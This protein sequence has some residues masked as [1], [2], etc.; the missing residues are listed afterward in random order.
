MARNAATVDIGINVPA[1]EIR[2]AEQQLG[3][4]FNKA[5]AF[6]K[7]PIVSKNY[8]QPLGRITGAANEFN[9]SLAAS[10]ARV[11]AFGASAGAIFA[12]QKAMSELVKTTI[13]VEQ[14][15][16]NI[17]VLLGATD[18]EFRRFSDGLFKTAQA[19][20]KSFA[21]VAASAEEFARQ[22]LNVE[23][24]LK[25]NNA[26]MVLSKLGAMDVKNA[27]ESLTAAINTF[28]KSAGD[29]TTIV[30]KLAQV[31]AKFAVSSGDL[32]EAIKRSGAAAVSANVEFEQFISV[33][34]LAQERTA[35]GGAVIGNSF[36]TI[37]T[38][39][40]RNETLRELE[41]L[42]VATRNFSTG[43]LLPAMTILKNYAK[44]YETLAPTVKASTAQM[45]AGVFQVNVLK[46]VLPELAN[47]YGRYNQALNVANST[48]NEATERMKELTSTTQGMLNKT[49]VNL[50]KFASE[51]GNL[52]IKPALER[53]LKLMNG[54]ADLIGP[55]NFFGLGETIGTAVY[56]GMGKIIE[57]P[58]LLLL[59]VVIAKI[60]GRLGGYVKD[61]AAGFMGI[62]TQSQ[63]LADTQSIIQNLLANRP[64]L[65]NQAMAS[66]EGMVAVVRVLA[67]KLKES[68]MEM[69]RLTAAAQRAA[70][71]VLAM[72]GGAKSAGGKK[73]GAKGFVPGFASG[74][75]PNFNMATQERRMASAGGYQAG[76]I[77]EA[78]LPGVGRVTYNGNEKI[79][80]FPGLEQPGIM[81]PA[82]SPAGK[83]YRDSFRGV[84]G[85]DPY[86]SAGGFVPNFAAKS[87]MIGGKAYTG[88]QVSAMLRPTRTQPRAFTAEEAAAAGYAPSGTSQAQRAAGV[89]RQNYTTGK[90]VTKRD[91]AHTHPFDVMGK[92]GIL[93]FTSEVDRMAQASMFIKNISAMNEVVAMNPALANDKILFNNV[94]VRGVS[95]LSKKARREEKFFSKISDYLAQPLAELTQFFSQSV[96]GN[97][98]KLNTRAI[99]KQLKGRNALLPPGAEGD[100]FEAVVKILTTEPQ[101]LRGAFDAKRNFKAPFDFEEV[102]KATPKFVN[103]FGFADTL[104]R[105]DAKRS[106]TATTV[107]TVVKK[108]IN[109]ALLNPSRSFAKAMQGAPGMSKDSAITPKGAGGKAGYHTA[110]TRTTAAIRVGNLG[111]ALGFVPNFAAAGSRMG[112]KEAMKRSQATVSAIQREHQAGIPKNQIRVGFDKRIAGGVGVF[113]TSETS[114]GN[115]IN[116]HMARGASMRD[117]QTMGA[118]GGFVPNFET[119][120]YLAAN[121]PAHKGGPVNLDDALPKQASG[122]RSVATQAAAQVK[123]A[124]N[125]LTEG[126]M[127]MSMALMMA[128]SQASVFGASL[129]ESQSAVKRAAGEFISL[130][131]TVAMYY[132]VIQMATA[133]MG[134]IS[135]ALALF[136]TKI[137]A[138]G[139]AI[140]TS[141]KSFI[142]NS[143]AVA[144]STVAQGM[145][146]MMFGVGGGM[147]RG[148]GRA[149]AAYKAGSM[150]KI[151]GPTL[152]G[153]PGLGRTKIGGLAGVRG[154]LA[155]VGKRMGGVVGMGAR[156]GA[157]VLGGGA[158]TV[159]AGAAAAYGGYK[160]YQ[161][162]N[163]A[164]F[165]EVS[166]KLSEELNLAKDKTEKFGK[167]L[168]KAGEVLSELDKQQRAG[169][170]TTKTREQLVASLSGSAFRDMIGSQPGGSLSVPGVGDGSLSRAE[171]LKIMGDENTSSQARNDIMTAATKLKDRYARATDQ[172]EG[173]NAVIDTIKD[174]QGFWRSTSM[175]AEDIAK[176]GGNLADV[177]GE[178]SSDTA[179]RLLPEL[180]KVEDA[181]SNLDSETVLSTRELKVA[182][183]KLGDFLKNAPIEAKVRQQLIGKLKELTKTTNLSEDDLHDFYKKVLPY[184]KDELQGLAN[185]GAFVGNN[186][187]QIPIDKLHNAILGIE[188]EFNALGR[189]LTFNKSLQAIFQDETTKMF[190]LASKTL[191][192]ELGKTAS[193]LTKIQITQELARRRVDIS[194]QDKLRKIE[195]D[196]SKQMFDIVKKFVV[197][198][199]S[200]TE[201]Q[202]GV[203]PDFETFDKVVGGSFAK[204]MRSAIADADFASAQQLIQNA[205]NNQK[206]L[207]TAG[208]GLKGGTP[209]RDELLQ[210]ERTLKDLN[211]T[212]QNRI[213]LERQR[214]ASEKRYIDAQ[215]Q[216]AEAQLSFAQRLKFLGGIQGAAGKPQEAR[217]LFLQN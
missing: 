130:A 135:G 180:Q 162:L 18:K 28:G 22:G 95:K 201:A 211:A 6:N 46:S 165:G 153:Q 116:M 80:Q 24:T 100:I 173:I 141:T 196:S 26:A 52:T 132:P 119:I 30:N 38:R 73:I 127:M 23:A 213:E 110:D 102:G 179:K 93:G 124:S 205:L 115:A 9:K 65:I 114:L 75:V 193:E 71:A 174:N 44:V 120:G 16:K 21:D 69:E 15:L 8:T 74:F 215:K 121:Q 41:K 31:D 79:K 112:S 200:S 88:L 151:Q 2:K 185:A 67:A 106:A 212:Q 11:I 136:G 182:T 184:V 17:E 134:G 57:G 188:T 51:V 156:G 171:I 176:F 181:F 169:G 140:S 36:K 189:Q 61:A 50:T 192:S 209:L 43:E 138:M 62:Q 83:N 90:N 137:K 7:N 150:A 85:F 149:R 194:S 107:D 168:S 139:V 103:T 160:I 214:N 77:R 197:P 86:N 183:N 125:T 13:Q 133:S 42:G 55:E 203:F 145:S 190:D 208:G 104:E 70:P 167:A 123:S 40:Q 49:M 158:A 177:F 53:I 14:Q 122:S 146:G 126:S 72:Q 175:T 198:K 92:L 87:Y 157:A 82:L 19:T 217:R 32:A 64:A 5:Q 105:A 154:G 166:R 27:T 143:R 97:Q 84:H 152:P 191:Q 54:F 60:A 78:T 91:P 68:S 37:F 39:L 20:G 144:G 59:G 101:H 94:Q 113:N 142:A 186:L 66:E 199:S 187:K 172:V 204:Q 45:L 117:I 25:R 159:A 89:T 10:N 56:K 207:A 35:R 111:K 161:A 109:W 58:G 48:T 118:A 155:N 29:A 170:D 1:S 148:M 128:G 3:A 206:S 81:P 98:G 129:Q 131:G 178:V 216:A 47:E 195:E 147:G 63:K 12:V 76:K 108:G 202:A 210:M 96:M 34:T 163:D 33:V 4:L 99:T 164:D